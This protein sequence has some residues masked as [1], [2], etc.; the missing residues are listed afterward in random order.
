[1]FGLTLQLESFGALAEDVATTDV[2]DD[3]TLTFTLRDEW[4][5]D[6]VFDF[7][8][9]RNGSPWIAGSGKYLPTIYQI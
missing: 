7:V 1:L 3:G 8:A 4:L 9:N 6:R 5:V 2:H